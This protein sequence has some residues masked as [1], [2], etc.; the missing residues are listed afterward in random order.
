MWR[1]RLQKA[2]PSYRSF[3]DRLF[4][5]TTRRENA[6]PLITVAFDGRITTFDNV[7]GDGKDE[8]ILGTQVRQFDCDLF[9]FAGT[10]LTQVWD[11]KI[12]ASG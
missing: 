4:H 11:E 8:L 3:E 12:N 1:I 6:R 2:T 7:S 5:G 9:C 10:D